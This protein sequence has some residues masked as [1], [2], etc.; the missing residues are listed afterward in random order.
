L[1]PKCIE[2]PELFE[3]RLRG[4]VAEL[5]ARTSHSEEEEN[6]LVQRYFLARRLLD[7]AVAG[8]S[9][10]TEAL[11]RLHTLLPGLNVR[12]VPLSAEDVLRQCAGS[13][14][15]T[16]EVCVVVDGV[17][18]LGFEAGDLADL[19]VERKSVFETVPALLRAFVRRPMGGDGWVD[20]DEVVD[21]VVK[22]P[23]KNDWDLD[24]AEVGGWDDELN[25]DD[26]DVG[27]GDGGEGDDEDILSSGPEG[28]DF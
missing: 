13:L 21:S 2:S 4:V 22:S 28:W 19:A 5:A 26:L 7:I 18:G 15:L 17:S 10:L 11:A 12:R 27:G 16:A 20:G 6:Q 9:Q 1:F 3:D 8:G 23:V 25:V 24:G 14:P